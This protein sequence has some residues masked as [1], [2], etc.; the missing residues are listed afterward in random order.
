[1]NLRV[2]AFQ[3]ASMLELEDAINNFLEGTV[4]EFP[5]FAMTNVKFNLA[6]H[7]VQQHT[8]MYFALVFYT[9]VPWNV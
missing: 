1:M 5:H 7:P 8:I 9:G 2:Q 3:A 4:R 6:V